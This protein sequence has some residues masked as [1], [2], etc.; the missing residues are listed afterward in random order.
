MVLSLVVILVPTLLIVWFFTRTPDQPQV[1][2]VD[3]RPMVASARGSAGYPVLA[4]VEV[5]ADWKPVK[6]RYVN[7]GDQWVGDTQAVGNRLEL[8]FLSGDDIYVAV[9]QSDEPDKDSY[10][11]SVTRSG[12]ADGHTDID[13]QTWRRLVTE[14]GRTRALVRSEGRS[15]AVVVGDTGYAALETF[16]QTLK[17]S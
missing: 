11:A 9:D 2:Q 8:G 3:W 14:D 5:P 13:G 15:T 6:A 4:P 16:A 12:R 1:D 7:R 10:V 17:T